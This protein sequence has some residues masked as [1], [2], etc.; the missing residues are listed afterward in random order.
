VHKLGCDQPKTTKELLD[1]ATQHA[2][3]EE[4][5]GVVFVQGDEK[6]IPVSSRWEPSKATGKDTK[7]GAKDSKK[8]AKAAPPWITATTSCNDDNKEA[9][10]SDEEYITATK[11]DIKR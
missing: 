1:I 8:G 11:H 9:D 10:G 2:S 3:G 5:V 4:A 6:M 7:K